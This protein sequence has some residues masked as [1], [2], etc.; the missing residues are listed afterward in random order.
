MKLTVG[1]NAREK[2]FALPTILLVS[3]VMI[4]I[5]VA[6]IAAAAASRVSLDSQYYNHLA[7]QAAESGI[8]R[9]M[10]CLKSSGYSPQWTTAASS[11]DLRPNSDCTGA[12]RG[13]AS[14][15]VVGDGTGPS[16]NIR[17]TY[18]IDAPTGT[19]IGSI[20]RVNGKTELV[21]GTS[22]GTVWRTYEQSLYHRIEPPQAIACP[23]GF[24]TVAGNSSFGTTDFCISKYEA[25]NVGG[26]AASVP[27][28]QPYVNISQDNARIAA[29]NACSGCHLV[30]EAEWMTV[31]AD[32]LGVS[33][34]WSGGAVGTGY[35]YSGHNDYAPADS[36]AASTDDGDGYAGT[37][38]TTGSNQRRTLTLSNGEI[39]WDLAGNVW[40][41]TDATIAGGQQPGLSGESAYAWKQWNNGS[42]LMNGL[43][44]NSR[45][46][47]ISGASGWTSSNGI[48]Q[49]YS[50]YGEAG[51]RAFLRGGAWHDGSGAGV[52]T[53]ALSRTPSNALTSVGFRVAF[54]PLSHINCREGF[55]PVPGNNMFSTNDFC[56][57]KYEAKNVSGTATSQAA[58][59]PWGAVTQNQAVTY[60]NAACANCRLI[61]EAEWLTIAHNALNVPSNWSTGT[62]GSGYIYSGHTDNTPASGQAASANDND[63]Y[64]LT[65]NSAGSNQRRTLALSNGEV[66]WDFSGNMS[67]W[68]LGQHTGSGKPGAAGNA[69]REWNAVPVSGALSPS[70]FPAFGTSAASAY[71]SA[72]RIGRLYSNSTDT[73]LRGF[74]RS[75]AYNYDTSFPD[76]A[77]LFMLYL[78]LA[79]G[80][81]AANTSFR[82]VEVK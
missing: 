74:L 19:G 65:G 81:S 33:S 22:P 47:A 38:N 24:A 54:R 14:L 61:N 79:P 62:V 43:P 69:W 45:A 55:I 67:E 75:S 56:A 23:E 66:I 18:T 49:L 4:A 77:G 72:N 70:P 17:T 21:R 36:L 20:L 78:G 29:A 48:G 59:A 30:T 50:N 42:L 5:L 73:A 28:G 3:T 8:A 26:K 31:A 9:A 68:T 27:E 34:N 57:A 1:D 76:N 52:L 41:W 46:S 6:S 64:Y 82:M 40:E 51:A 16:S 15:Y 37:G 2:G 11:R 10:E 12:T 71:T 63:G 25:K 32:A 80:D 7:K 58:G 39:I 44:S 13:G 53:L 60:A 35:I